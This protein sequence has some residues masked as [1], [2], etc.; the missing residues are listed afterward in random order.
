MRCENDVSLRAAAPFWVRRATGE[1][2]SDPA[3]RSLAKKAHRHSTLDFALAPR[4]LV[5]QHEPARSLEWRR[6][7]LF[8]IYL[9]I[10]RKSICKY[11][12]L[13]M[14]QWEISS[15]FHHQ[16]YLCSTRVKFSL[17]K[18]ILVRPLSQQS[19]TCLLKVGMS[20]ASR[21]SSHWFPEEV[22]EFLFSELPFF[23]KW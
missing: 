6:S 8:H 15:L 16:R 9:R 19:E 23:F 7:K 1:K 13:L 2:P 22:N 20:R 11:Y 17:G 3:W 5:F 10:W 18:K 14:F 21:I 4:A 12:F